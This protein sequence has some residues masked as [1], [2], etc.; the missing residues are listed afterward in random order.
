[1]NAELKEEISA[2]RMTGEGYKLIA[3]E[4]GLNLNSVRSYCRRNGL[5]GYAVD[6]AAKFGISVS[7][8]SKKH[9]SNSCKKHCMQCGKLF[10]PR[11]NKQKFCST[12]C[13]T[14][15]R[16]YKERTL[17]E[18]VATI[19]SGKPVTHIPEWMFVL[20]RDAVLKR[21]AEDQQSTCK[22]RVMPKR[23]Y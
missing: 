10:L 21:E 6:I 9:Q 12:E 17:I 14:D 7:E 4:L 18:F 23:V 3:S 2:R 1:M 13:F 5:G 22:S 11:N 20:L 8:H 19:R 15:F 16:F